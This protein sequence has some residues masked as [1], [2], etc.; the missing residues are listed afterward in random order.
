MPDAEPSN[1][2]EDLAN[3]NEKQ[4]DALAR[5]QFG[6][7]ARR[8]L[9]SLLTFSGYAYVAFLL[10]LITSLRSIGEKNLTLAFILYL[11]QVAWLLPMPFILLPALLW[12]R[13]LFLTLVITSCIFIWSVMGYRLGSD[14]PIPLSERGSD[15]LTLVSYN[16]GQQGNRRLQ[17]FKNLVKPDILLIQEGGISSLYSEGNGYNEFSYTAEQGEY[18]LLSKYPIV[19]TSPVTFPYP[20]FTG[21]RQT[22]ATRFEI[23]WDGTRVAIYDVHLPTPRDILLYYRKGAFLYGIIGIPGTPLAEK[24]R[25]NQLYWDYRLALSDSLIQVLKAEDL[26]MV[27]VG[28]FNA[29][30][31]GYN[32]RLFDSFL[33]D[34]H[35]TSGSGFGYTFPGTTR[36]P[37]SL[38]GPW[39]RLDYIFYDDNWQSL[40]CL[41]EKKRPSQHRAVAA[42]LKL[43]T[44]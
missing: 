35:K 21:H 10:I 29:P 15:T 2:N 4:L 28:D 7:L 34:A 13:R 40:R 26:P 9:K 32:H 30:H 18:A 31:A 6:R 1:P 24:R 22:V 43:T 16:H 8:L 3:L 20:P 27:V 12:Q 38:G 42:T 19:S 25:D 44:K 37:L 23:D 11:P 5:S 41:A 14:K 17:R 36:N 39:L 33:S